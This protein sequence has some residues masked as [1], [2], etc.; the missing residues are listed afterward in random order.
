MFMIFFYFAEIRYR[1]FYSIC[2][3]FFSFFVC[4]SCSLELL[5]LFARPFLHSFHHQL[6]FDKGFIFTNLTEAFQTTLKVCFVW[7]LLFLLPL[8]FYQSW[9]F[10]APSWYLFERKRAKKGLLFGALCGFLGG[11]TF[12]SLVLPQILDFLLGFKVVSPLFTIQLQARI[13]SYVTLSSTVFLIVEG[14]FQAPLSIYFLYLYRCVDSA[15]F[16][17]NRKIFVLFFLFLSAL[18][19]PPDLLTELALFFFFWFV[20]ECTVWVGFLEWKRE[21]LKEKPCNL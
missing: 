10:F 5:Y 1:F 6:F 16:S 8:I 3:F 20:F 21:S 2:S 15:F 17:L 7:S 13:D 14:V 18:L 11:F 9:C 4:Y 12:Y 19:S